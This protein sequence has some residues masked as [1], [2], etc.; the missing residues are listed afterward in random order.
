MTGCKEQN[1]NF[2]RNLLKKWYQLFQLYTH[3]LLKNIGCNFSFSSMTFKS[4][5][6]QNDS[7]ID[8]FALFPFSNLKNS[9][10]VLKF[11]F[12][13][14]KPNKIVVG[15]RLNLP[16]QKLASINYGFRM[17]LNFFPILNF[18]YVGN[19]INMNSF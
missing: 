2:S 18:K 19:T 7:N 10:H 4:Q 11:L 13:Q 15:S 16:W 6:S 5:K 12:W 17:S 14:Q 1:P 8:I 9:P 3:L